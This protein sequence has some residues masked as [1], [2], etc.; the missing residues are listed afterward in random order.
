MAR[1]ADPEASSATKPLPSNVTLTQLLAAEVDANMITAR[2]D[3]SRAAASEFL[4]RRS[5]IVG[6]TSHLLRTNE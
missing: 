4:V 6:M 1:F 2:W 5:I 3:A